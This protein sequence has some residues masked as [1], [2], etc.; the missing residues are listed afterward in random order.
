MA[1]TGTSE[2]VSGSSVTATEIREIRE[3]EKREMRGL[4]DRLAA[5]IEQVRFLEAQNRKL[6]HDLERLTKGKHAPGIRMMYEKEISV[7]TSIIQS[8]TII[9]DAKRD[10][11]NSEKEVRGLTADLTDIRSKYDAAVKARGLGDEDDLIV[12]LCNL[13]AQICMTKRRNAVIDEEC[14][15]IRAENLKLS[16]DLAAQRQLLEKESLQRMNY[17][18]QAQALIEECKLIASSNNVKLD[19]YKYQDTTEENR[20]IFRQGLL[21]AIAEIRRLYDEDTSKFRSEME[22]WYSKQVIEIRTSVLQPMP[23]LRRYEKVKQ[24]RSQLTE[25]RTNLANLEGR[26]HILEKL[27]Q[28]L[29]YQID[30][31]SR[32]TMAHLSE[33]DDEIRAVRAQCQAITV[34]LE[35]LIVEKVNLDAEISK[36]RQ[37]LEGEENRTHGRVISTASHSFD[38]S[39]TTTQCKFWLY[40]YL[41]Y[42]H[43][44]DVAPDG[45][46]ITI[47]NTSVSHDEMIGEWRLR[48]FGGGRDVSFTFPRGFVL[49]PKTKVTVYARGKGVYAPPHSLVF[50]AEDSFA[51]GR[52]VHTYLYN[53]ANQERASVI[54]RS[55]QY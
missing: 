34:E 45:S 39:A 29:N 1:H 53:D 2:F 9:A 54:H 32:V 13:Q 20:A 7:T 50:E 8:Q 55:S 6:N 19:K 35:K 5:Y 48:S 36:Y 47:E 4:N 18:H 23:P 46:F 25:M 42:D 51:T 22:S 15:R 24:L 49:T 37:L 38:T 3:R 52:D 17:E 16:S 26:N 11:G 31:E 44:E 40:F 43:Y 10:I 28:D 14:K 33:K 27:I 30:D 41:L 21:E 12:K